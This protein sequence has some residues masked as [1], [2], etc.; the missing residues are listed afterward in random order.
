MGTKNSA[1]PSNSSTLSSIVDSNT[2]SIERNTNYIILY[3]PNTLL[4]VYIRLD[5]F[6]DDT[7]L[8]TGLDAS[9]LVGT[10]VTNIVH[11]SHSLFKGIEGF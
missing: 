3:R 9:C 2:T 8:H 7:S 6:V 5:R 4:L 11:V 10:S 1:D